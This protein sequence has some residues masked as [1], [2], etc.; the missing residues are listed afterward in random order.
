M[1]EWDAITN[2]VFGKG[3]LKE[4]FDKAKAQNFDNHVG[5]VFMEYLI[6]LCSVLDETK[7]NLSTCSSGKF[8]PGSSS[9]T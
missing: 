3:G 7:V 5:K 4:I 1:C 2:S 6:R 9:F 8:Q